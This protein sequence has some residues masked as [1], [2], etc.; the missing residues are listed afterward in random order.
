MRATLVFNLDLPEDKEK[1]DE[2]TSNNH[3]NLKLAMHDFAQ[4]VLRR[5]RKYDI[6]GISD[7]GLEVKH[8]HLKSQVEAAH[9]MVVHLEK[10]FYAKL[11]EYDASIE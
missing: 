4:D 1:F 11:E 5:Y 10:Q 2:I 3:A 6:P 7:L 9:A 8:G